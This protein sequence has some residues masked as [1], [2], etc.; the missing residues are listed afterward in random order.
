LQIVK[1]IASKI[2]LKALY[3]KF[4]RAV[5][6]ARWKKNNSFAFLSVYLALKRNIRR[7]YG[8]DLTL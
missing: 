4:K 7:R 1:T 2:V 3:R 6:E 5:D 8:A